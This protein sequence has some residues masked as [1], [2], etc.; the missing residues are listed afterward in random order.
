MVTAGRSNRKSITRNSSMFKPLEFEFEKGKEE[1]DLVEIDF[2]EV[3]KVENPDLSKVSSV[4]KSPVL[5]KSKRNQK[6]SCVQRLCS[7]VI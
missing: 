7:V 4:D 1:D 3:P 6:T 2:D 5:R